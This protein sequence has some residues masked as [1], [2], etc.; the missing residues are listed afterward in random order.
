M[1]VCLADKLILDP[2]PIHLKNN[3]NLTDGEHLGN[4]MPVQEVKISREF[5]HL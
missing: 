4:A 5:V 3:L 2:I 1:A